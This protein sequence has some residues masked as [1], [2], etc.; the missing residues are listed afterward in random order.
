M[1]YSVN[2]TTKCWVGARWD[3]KKRYC[4]NVEML[5]NNK[6]KT[7]QLKRSCL[8]GKTVR[9]QVGSNWAWR[10]E[11]SSH[12]QVK[13][14]KSCDLML[15][16]VYNTSCAPQ[17]KYQLSYLNKSHF[18]IFIFHFLLYNAGP[19]KT[20]CMCRLKSYND[21]IHVDIHYRLHIAELCK[22]H[23]PQ[24]DRTDIS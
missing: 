14:L 10:D 17:M 3:K 24:S 6:K 19:Q 13:S 18:I 1:R 2:M 11:V 12:K 7:Q 23:L 22:E 16:L 4:K 9:C 15:L 20:S 5:K 8:D 21:N